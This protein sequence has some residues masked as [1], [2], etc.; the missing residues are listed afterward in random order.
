MKSAGISSTVSTAV[1]TD[2]EVLD[3]VQRV[4]ILSQKKG[5]RGKRGSLRSC[6]IFGEVLAAE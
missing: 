3:I 2:G 1:M 5:I 4:E 6:N